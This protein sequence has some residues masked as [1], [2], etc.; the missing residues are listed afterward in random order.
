MKKIFFIVLV[1]LVNKTQAQTS[2]Y[3]IIPTS[4]T[5]WRENF[6]A[7]ECSNCCT[8]YQYFITGDTL[9]NNLTYHKIKI[10]G[11]NYYTNMQGFCTN[12][13]TSYYNEYT[14]AFRNDSINKKV[15]FLPANSTTDTLLYDF[16]LNLGDTLPPSLIN[17][18][19]NATPYSSNH[20]VTNIDSFIVG[21]SYHKRFSISSNEILDYVYL[22]EGIGSTMGFLGPICIP[23]EQER[24]LLC[25]TH[26]GQT[27]YPDTIYQCDLISKDAKIPFDNN[28]I[29]LSPNP[30]SSYT[31]IDSKINFYNA[32]ILVYNIFGKVVKQEKN[33]NNGNR[34]YRENLSSGMYFFK[35]IENNITFYNGKFIID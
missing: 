26:N 10:S 34:I 15:F 18:P 2:V 14:G 12:I 33:I 11:V 20:Y 32:D 1:L 25:F 4:N 28:I 27:I 35:L 24:Q 5:I 6:A 3:N 16:D 23:F 21:N 13:I 8:D 19:Y 9:V 7:Y 29:I 31:I 30:F 22:I 17:C